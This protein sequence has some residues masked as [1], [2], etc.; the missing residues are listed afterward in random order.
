ML[1]E[2]FG[3][4][5]AVLIDPYIR[6]PHRR[7]LLVIMLLVYTLI[8][9]NLLD[10]QLQFSPDLILARTV[11]SVYGYCGRPAILVLFMQLVS[12]EKR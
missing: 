5:L 3:L 7:Y 9:Q 2:L 1:L 10:Y 11:V 12:S 8:A 4:T 6:K